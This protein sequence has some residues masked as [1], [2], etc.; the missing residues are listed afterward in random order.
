MTIFEEHPPFTTR[1]GAAEFIQAYHERAAKANFPDTSVEVQ[2]ALLHR[3]ADFSKRPSR[4]P[5][6]CNDKLMADWLKK[7]RHTIEGSLA[8][9]TVRSTT[10][11]ILCMG[12][13]SRTASGGG[14]A[15]RTWPP[16]ERS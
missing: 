3:V 2:A 10:A 5:R 12:S 15:A 9:R 8:L 14:L 7:P 1:P 6:A 16:R 4:P 13:N 11:T